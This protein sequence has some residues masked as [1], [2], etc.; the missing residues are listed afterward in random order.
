MPNMIVLCIAAS[1]A[2]SCSGLAFAQ[3]VPDPVPVHADAETD[4]MNDEGPALAVDDAGNAMAVW[5]RNNV[6]STPELFEVVTAIRKAETGTWSAPVTVRSQ[7][8]RTALVNEV[9]VIY[10]G[11]GAWVCQWVSHD[12][13]TGY[14]KIESV[15]STDFGATWSAPVR[16]D[17]GDTIADTDGDQEISM[18]ANGT[19]H[20][21]ATW[22]TYKSQISAYEQV[23]NLYRAESTDYGQTWSDAVNWRP[24]AD[25]NVHYS[26]THLAYNGEGIWIH[27]FSMATQMFSFSTMSASV[28]TSTDLIN[29][30]MSDFPGP[31]YQ[32]LDYLTDVQASGNT[33]I[34]TNKQ[35]TQAGFFH[36][37]NISH[38]AGQAWEKIEYAAPSNYITAKIAT[39]D[40]G[41]WKFISDARGADNTLNIYQA[42][43]NS[44][45]LPMVFEESAPIAESLADE[46]SPAVVAIGRGQFLVVY[47]Y[48]ARLP[49]NSDSNEADIY[50]SLIRTK[51]QG[52]P[53]TLLVEPDKLKVKY[54]EPK[55]GKQPKPR[56]LQ[57]K[58]SLTNITDAI[59]PAAFLNAYFSAD[60]LLSEEDLPVFSGSTKK[61][62]KPG[63]QK[64]IKIKV[65]GL[66]D[67]AGKYLILQVDNEEP[68]PVSLSQDLP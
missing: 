21:V 30:N 47:Q 50:S 56:K 20:I 23:N 15:R 39:D 17:I 58:V 14:T 55:P 53:V 35:Q 8:G 66:P 36:Y 37:A 40:L 24:R 10:A 54:K 4:T 63:K 29:W 27:G 32:Y 11:N 16:T 18:A 49:D 6:L 60:A 31:L 43:G 38:D 19:G 3:P 64:K 48:V 45:V 28:D 2:A 33:I 25:R 9:E 42:E 57:M 67:P 12:P 34:A 44:T 59:R 62:I 41:S 1:L 68:V 5:R 52:D 22:I 61:T 13:I 46:R 65:I 26:D 7:T 51:S